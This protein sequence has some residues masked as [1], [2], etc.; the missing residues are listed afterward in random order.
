MEA[1]LPLHDSLSMGSQ[2]P[3]FVLPWGTPSIQHVHDY[4]SFALEDGGR[5]APQW[6]INW[7]LIAWHFHLVIFRYVTQAWVRWNLARCCLKVLPA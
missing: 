4:H 1:P 7:L 6:R 2:H 5:L 3:H